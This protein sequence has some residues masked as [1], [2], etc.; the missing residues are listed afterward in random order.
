[1]NKA[2]IAREV[3][4]SRS[5]VSLQV[6]GHRALTPEVAAAVARHEAADRAEAA[7]LM[8]PALGAA[9]AGTVAAGIAQ[10][11]AALRG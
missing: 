3:G 1:M 4:V 10:A 7:R 5:C 11:R 8:A 2:Q 6:H 9:V